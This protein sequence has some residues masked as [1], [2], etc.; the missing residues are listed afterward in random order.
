MR[1]G[2][3]RMGI[4]AALLCLTT[5]AQAQVYIGRDAP[6]RG[7]FEASGGGMF[8]SG[9][10]LGELT[11]E[12]TRSTSTD[13]F[14]LFTS[15]VE[16]T[17]FPGAFA[18]LGYYLSDGVSIEGGMRYARPRLTVRLSRDAESAPNQTAEE[19]LSHYVFEGSLVWHLRHLSFASGRAIPYLAGGAGYLRELHEGNQLVETGQV[20]QALAGMKFWLG[21]SARRFGLRVE[22]GIS[23]R[24]KGIDA[25]DTVRALP[26]VF[27]GVSYLF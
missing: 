6:R 18:R 9:F 22:G 10:A 7:M 13:R 8:A 1:R 17:G 3:H 25:E 20:Y 26:I 14:D 24:K 21:S 5:A 23:A 27:G 16:V 12:L 19:T 2:A 4:C 15:E 11:A